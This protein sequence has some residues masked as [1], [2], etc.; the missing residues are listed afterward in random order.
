MMSSSQGA[1]GARRSQS[2]IPLKAPLQP[3]HLIGQ[4]L[5]GRYRMLNMVGQG[6]MSRVYRAHQLGALQREVAV[7]VLRGGPPFERAVMRRFE[8]EARVIAHLRHPSA[9][10]MFDSGRLADGSLYVVTEYLHG[11]S[12]EQERL[13]S[14][15]SL[16]AVLRLGET[17]AD[18]LT[19]AHDQGIVHRDLKPANIFMERIGGRL[20]VKVIDFG[21]ARITNFPGL[22]VAEEI[23]GTPGYMAPEQYRGA[24]V[25]GT[26]DIYALGVILWE[27][28]AGKLMFTGTPSEIAMQHLS[29]P[30][31]GLPLRPDVTRPEHLELAV[32]VESMLRK[33]PSLRPSAVEVRER[34]SVMLRSLE[35]R[36]LPEQSPEQNP[37]QDFEE[38]TELG[39]PVELAPA[40]S[41]A[42]WGWMGWAALV[43]GAAALIFAVLGIVAPELFEVWL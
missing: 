33:E 19:E 2:P 6:G 20:W 42:W 36:R 25:S 39:Q 4:V 37:G 16:E 43:L 22:T 11:R 21:I 41:T 26:A 23:L 35:K 3:D 28:M 40:P 27:C 9:L 1:Q 14:L 31:P 8:N 30:M 17:V 29:E 24:K 5:E 7:K 32:L 13:T 34:L 10:K 38:E 18:V 12:L 15:L